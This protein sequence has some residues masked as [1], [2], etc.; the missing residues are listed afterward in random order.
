M[1]KIFPYL[2]KSIHP[3]DPCNEPQEQET[4]YNLWDLITKL[5]KTVNKEEKI[6]KADRE[7]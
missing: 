1:T 2:M 3:Q 5:L 6:L 4:W 7:K